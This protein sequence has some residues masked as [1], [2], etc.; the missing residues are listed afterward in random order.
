MIEM[1]G[2]NHYPLTEESAPQAQ[3]CWRLGANEE[4]IREIERIHL[5]SAFGRS[6]K[7][8]AKAGLLTYRSL[9][10]RLSSHSHKE[11]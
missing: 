7:H 8:N 6:G 5:P 1:T 2:N 9:L 10:R 4:E 11:Q 3:T